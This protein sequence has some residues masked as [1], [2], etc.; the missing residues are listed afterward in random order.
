[1]QQWIP[2]APDRARLSPSPVRRSRRLHTLERIADRVPV[3]NRYRAYTP[4]LSDPKLRHLYQT[5]PS[6]RG[7][8]LFKAKDRLYLTRSI[9]RAHVDF[10]LLEAKGVVLGLSALHDASRGERVNADS[11]LRRWVTPWREH[12]DRVGAPYVTD[13]AMEEGNRV[14]PLLVPWSQ[15]LEE[16][17]RA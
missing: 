12:G 1:M 11:L 9:L 16:V 7:R 14:S 15:P 6:V 3:S 8:T 13:P 4:L 17:R 5:Y 10:G 2:P